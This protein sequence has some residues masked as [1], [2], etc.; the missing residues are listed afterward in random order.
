MTPEQIINP[1][2]ILLFSTTEGR[3][4]WVKQYGLTGF[5]Q[6][7]LPHHFTLESA[8]MHHEIIG[9]L[10]DISVKF[11]EII[12]FRGSAKTTISTLAFLLWE[13]LENK[14]PFII[15]VGDTDA[16][17]GVNMANVIHE[18]ESNELL[19]IDY[20]AQDEQS[21][22]WTQHVIVLSEHQRLMSMGR[23]QKIRGL[24]H[25]QYRPRLVIIDDP[26]ESKHIGQKKYRDDSERWLR[27]EVIPAIDE[28]QGRIVMLG[29]MLHT[30]GLMARMRKDINWKCLEFPLIKNGVVAWPAKYPDQAALDRK[31]GEAGPSMWQREYLLKVVPDEGQ[32]VKDEWIQYYDEIPE[33]VRDEKGI[34]ISNPILSAGV[35]NDLAI[36]KKE[37]ADYTTFVGV[38]MAQ[39]ESRSHIFVLKHPVNERLSFQETIAT[40]KA[41]YEA[42]KNKYA[43]PLF[44][45]EDVAYQK[46]AI[47]MLGTA[48]IPVQGVKVGTDKRARLTLAAPFIENGTV[49]FPRTGCEDLILQLLGF[50]VEEHDDLVDAFVNV[51]LGINS[52]SGMQPLDVV[53][54][55]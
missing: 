10:S 11:L 29:N 19:R 54:I 50:G 22:N 5:C 39:K 20:G 17:A 38:V 48:G 28:T 40:G 41:R 30:D 53:Q 47:E 49:L 1:N 15:A 18:L 36:S 16:Q 34:I 2:E 26:E 7:Y 43:A 33:V 35:G 32:V 31:R 51:V 46:V 21:K 37:T 4:S 44:F 55:L 42:I 52:I 23:G 6:V 25:M 8:D 24:K 9:A 27:G 3:R 12:A 45:T 14:N 13:L